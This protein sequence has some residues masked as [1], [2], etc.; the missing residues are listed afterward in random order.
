MAILPYPTKP[1]AKPAAPADKKVSARPARQ[2]RAPLTPRRMRRRSPRR[3]SPMC[4]RLGQAS[5]HPPP[6][7]SAWACS[8]P[9]RDRSQVSQEHPSRACPSLPARPALSPCSRL[10]C[11]SLGRQ[12]SRYLRRSRDGADPLHRRSLRFQFQIS[13]PTSDHWVYFFSVLCFLFRFSSVSLHSDPNVSNSSYNDPVNS[14]K[15]RLRM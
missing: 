3:R 12:E 10:S 6:P 1:P 11:P 7:S 14:P 9:R 8:H 5:W 15:D 4:P 2:V 13:V